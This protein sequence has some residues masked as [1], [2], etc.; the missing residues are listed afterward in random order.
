MYATLEL[1]MILRLVLSCLGSSPIPFR[2]TKYLLSDAEYEAREV[3]VMPMYPVFWSIFWVVEIPCLSNMVSNKVI[4]F[5]ALFAIGGKSVIFS[6]LTLEDLVG[7]SWIPRSRIK[8]RVR[9]CD[10]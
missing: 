10:E 1:V 9:E 2:G 7:I 8:A 4:P 5:L 3:L 6:F